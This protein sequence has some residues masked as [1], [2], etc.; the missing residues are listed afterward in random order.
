[1][2]VLLRRDISVRISISISLPLEA[3][4]KLNGIILVQIAFINLKKLKKE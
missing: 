3:N 1:M 4:P 2:L